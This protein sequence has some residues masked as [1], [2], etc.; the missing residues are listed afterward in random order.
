MD[1]RSNDSCEGTAGRT[2]GRREDAVSDSPRVTVLTPGLAAVLVLLGVG[3][4]VTVGDPGNQGGP[5]DG[6]PLRWRSGLVVSVAFSPDGRSLSACG[7]EGSFALWDVGARRV[8][9]TSAGRADAGVRAAL[10]HD[11]ATVAVANR[12]ETVTLWDVATGRRRAGLPAHAE[13][14]RALAFT[15]D[16]AT[17]ASADGAGVRFWDTATGRPRPG[18]GFAVVGVRCLAVAPD[19]RTLA[20]GDKDGWVRLFDP[21]TGHQR[22]SF[23]AH[24]G[25]ILS[26]TFSDDGRLLASTSTPD[27]AARLWEVR[28]GRRLLDLDCRPGPVQAA[29]FAPGARTVATAER[30]GAVRLWDVLTGRLLRTLS[31]LDA[32]VTAIAFSPDGRTLAGGTSEAIWLWDVERLSRR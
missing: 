18:S 6:S 14:V 5:A 3:L 23:R 19:G 21:P 20:A 28:L 13:A 8:R 15:R 2:R 7:V 24:E 22:A 12:D 30:D 26:L 10:T 25:P 31:C 1:R 9:M 16:G 17:L 29:A 27:G 32:P 4:A 11:G